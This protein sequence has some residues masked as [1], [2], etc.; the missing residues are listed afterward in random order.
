[1]GNGMVALRQLFSNK[2]DFA[3]R[4]FVPLKDR[5]IRD[6]VSVTTAASSADYFETIAGK[7][8]SAAN[9][10]GDKSLVREANLFLILQLRAYIRDRVPT[11]AEFLPFFNEGY[12]QMKKLT[13]DT[14]T[15]DEDN[16]INLTPGVLTTHV[17]EASSGID[18][19]YPGDQRQ[20]GRRTYIVPENK[21]FPGGRTCEFNVSWNEGA[22]GLATTAELVVEAYGIEFEPRS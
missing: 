13:P 5:S 12:Y 1:M 3:N 8:K 18:E 14:I 7:R 6:T 15:I 22:N 2:V 17:V 10:Q 19:A 4:S 16:L 11:L 20:E 9:F 21:M